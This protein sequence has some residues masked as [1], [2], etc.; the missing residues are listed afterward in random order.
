MNNDI[1][2]DTK[3][4]SVKLMIG[5][6]A[7]YV[8]AGIMALLYELGPFEPGSVT[9][10]KTIY[11]LEV[12]GVLAS[13]A[14]IPLALRGF[15]KMV[16][17]LDEKEYP[18]DKIERVYMAC[19]WLRLL[20]FF[21][22]VEFGVLLYYLINDTIGLYIAAI[23]AICSMFAIPTKAGIEHETGFYG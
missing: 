2:M 1:E 22:V 11:I 10:A 19:S 16:D 18:E 3:K 9:D 8:I 15:K 23:G 17:R 5:W 4:M 13:L 21:V 12:V 14:L 20:A 6:M 7:I